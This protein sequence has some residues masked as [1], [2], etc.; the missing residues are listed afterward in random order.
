M[1]VEQ[2]QDL[3]LP[4]PDAD[5]HHAV[6]NCQELWALSRRRICRGADP[7]GID[8]PRTGDARGL[9]AWRSRR[10]CQG[11]DPTGTCSLRI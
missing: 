5:P 6:G 9:W 7:M 2:A 8:S 11:S 3:K 4:G 1:G 10:N